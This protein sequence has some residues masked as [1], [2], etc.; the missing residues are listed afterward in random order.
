MSHAA[1][2]LYLNRCKTHGV[3]NG[4]AVRT[5]YFDGIA[6]KTKKFCVVF[7]GTGA[8]GCSLVLYCFEAEVCQHFLCLSLFWPARGSAFLCLAVTAVA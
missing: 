2:A 8:G 3:T 7:A 5:L 4:N 6:L 1:R